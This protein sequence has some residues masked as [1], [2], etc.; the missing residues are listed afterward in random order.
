MEDADAVAFADSDAHPVPATFQMKG[1][2]RGVIDNM[3]VFE[4]C[5]HD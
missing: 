5:P 3:A 2:E 1:S 4:L